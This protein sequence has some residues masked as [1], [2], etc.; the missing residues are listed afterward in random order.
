VAGETHYARSGDIHIAYQVSGDGPVDLLEF[1]NGTYI[2][3]DE[4][5]DEPHWERYV[6]RLGSFSRLIRYDPRGIG[7]SDPLPGP[8]APTVQQWVADA[9]CVLDSAGVEQAAL[10]GAGLGGAI[11]MT[12]A[13]THPDRVRSLV[14]VNSAARWIVD[15]DYPFGYAR[16][17]AEAWQA[18]VR[19]PEQAGLSQESDDAA[20]LAPSLAGDPEFRRW[21]SRAARRGASPATAAVLSGTLLN[22]DVRGV[23]GDI[24]APTLVVHRRDNPFLVRAHAGYL[25]ERIAGARYV[26]LPGADSIPYAGDFD[27]LL[28]LVEEFLTGERHRPAPDRVLATILFTD[29]VGS[30]EQASGLGDRRWKELLQSHDQIVRRQLERFRGR[31]VKSTGDGVLATF[32]APAR[33]IHCAQ[34]IVRGAHQ[35]GVEVRA[36][37]HVG[38]VDLL[39]HD[40]GGIAVHIAARVAGEAP[41]GQVYVSRTVTDLVVGSDIAFAD[42]GMHTLRGV[43]GDWPLF[44]VVG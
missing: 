14:I 32:D 13:A 5:A 34:A 2:S 35:L 26:E 41:G 43:P 39:D 7:L 29:I 18:A 24:V 31:H 4:T 10:L 19:D 15:D 38:E 21:W 27:E 30:T 25:V 11:A 9:L 8:G 33:A 44:G 40:I 3:I 16:H 12:L 36:G 42:V 1:N 23:L 17:V 37:L 28:D 20:L 22:G 6:R